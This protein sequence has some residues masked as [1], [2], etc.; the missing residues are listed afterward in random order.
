M[1]LVFRQ[2]QNQLHRA[3]D[4]ALV[5]RDKERV[6]AARRCRCYPGPEGGGLVEAQGLMKLTD[7]PPSTQSIKRSASERICS[8]DTR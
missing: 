2:V 4:A 1:R 3:D 5:L 7:A 6:L 8:S